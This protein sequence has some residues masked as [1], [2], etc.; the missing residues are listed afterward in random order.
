[1][2]KT[3]ITGIIVA[4]LMGFLGMC[5]FEKYSNWRNSEY[6]VYLESAKVE[7][8]SLFTDGLVEGNAFIYGNLSAV[9]A[10]TSPDIEG[11]YI[12]LKKVTESRHSYWTG[13]SVAYRWRTERTE[14]MQCENVAFCNV[15]CDSD[16]FDLGSATY[17]I[18]TIREGNIRYKYYGVDAEILGTFFTTIKNDEISDNTKIYQGMTIEETLD[19]IVN[20]ET[21]VF[22]FWFLWV[23]LSVACIQ[24]VV[25]LVE[26]FSD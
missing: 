17:H 21:W 20:N 9:D 23:V 3:M 19:S 24:G 16:R 12:Y 13:K 1:M 25:Y 7:D 10:V 8:A 15:W 5:A 2:K 26:N 22:C 4:V 18:K 11:E 14:E 6:A